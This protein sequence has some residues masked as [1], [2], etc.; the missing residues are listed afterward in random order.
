MLLP[1]TGQPPSGDSI[2]SSES[3]LAAKVADSQTYTGEPLEE[4]FRLNFAWRGDPR[5]SDLGAEIMWAPHESQSEAVHTDAVTKWGAMGIP[6]EVR[7]E[8]LGFSPRQIVRIGEIRDAA[9]AAGVETPPSPD[10][11]GDGTG[12]DMTGQMVLAQGGN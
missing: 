10:G 6:D 2:Q 9:M 1:Q 7:W 4:V 8:A 3:G 11:A 12:V 5:G